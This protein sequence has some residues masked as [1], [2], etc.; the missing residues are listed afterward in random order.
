[1][2]TGERQVLKTEKFKRFDQK[3]FTL[4]E[5]MAAISILGIGLASLIALQTR[6]VDN[7]LRERQLLR[8]ALAAQYIMTFA[9]I[10]EEPPSTGSSEADLNDSLR[11]LGYFEGEGVSALERQYEGWLLTK[12]VTSVDYPGLKEDIMRRIDLSVSWSEKSSDRYSL[13]YFVNTKNISSQ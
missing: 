3:A 9:E 2:D 11:A 6:L 8:A 13:I 5:I 1:M 10:E 12:N 7:F 4:V